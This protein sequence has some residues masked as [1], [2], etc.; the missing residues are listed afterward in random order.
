MIIPGLVESIANIIQ[1][2]PDSMDSLRS[3]LDI[4]LVGWPEAQAVLNGWINNFHRRR[5]RVRDREAA[6][7]VRSD[8]VAAGTSEGVMGV[9]N[10]G[11]ELLPGDNNMRV[12]PQQQGDVRCVR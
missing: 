9:F 6:A 10:C 12:F 5:H 11:E 8:R 2:L 4:K 3:W 7:G 1:L